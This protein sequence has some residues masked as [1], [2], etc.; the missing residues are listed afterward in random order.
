M[1]ILVPS[2]S[3]MHFSGSGAETV[4]FGRPITHLYLTTSA[5]TS[6][7]FN[8]G[9][10]YMS[11]ADGQTHVLLN[12]NVKTLVFDAGTWNGVGISI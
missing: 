4:Q 5:S 2:A 8:G 6:V 12:V 9:D 3:H 11:L 10:G 7:S 1:A